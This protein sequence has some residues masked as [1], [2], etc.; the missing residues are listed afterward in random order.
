M[1]RRR[2]ASAAAAA[3]ANSETSLASRLG[4]ER[5]PLELA[6]S[7]A[8]EVVDAVA[9]AHQQ[10]ATFGRLT[11]ADFRV[12]ADGSLAVTAERLP[13]GDVAADAF[14]VGAV[15]YQL[16]TGFTPAQARARLQVSPLHDAPPA[17]QLNPAIDD[18]LEAMLAQLLARD[19]ARRPYSLRLVEVA[20]ADACEFLDLEPSRAA[21]LAW[22]RVAPALRVVTP[23]PVPAVR[24]TPTFTVLADEDVEEVEAFDDE[25]LEDEEDERDAAGPVRFDGWMIAACGFCVVAFAMATSL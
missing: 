10:R 12:E 6:L 23:P 21:I 5:L 3:P 22:A 20:L 15:L 14:A 24:H 16:F 18:A 19:P 8:V 1:T 9:T 4:A 2:F 11:P 25:D 17:S 13:G 7:L